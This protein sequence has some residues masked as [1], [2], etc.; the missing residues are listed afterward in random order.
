MLPQ[1]VYRQVASALNTGKHVIL[2]G[3]PGNGESRLAKAICEFAKD[4]IVSAA[5]AK[6]TATTE[7]DS[8]RP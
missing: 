8:L 7:L 3:P 5:V 2:T 1:T 6:S 4:R